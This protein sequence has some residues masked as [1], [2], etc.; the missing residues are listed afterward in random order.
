MMKVKYT[1]V[2]SDDVIK[3]VFQD[4]AIVVEHIS[5]ELVFGKTLDEPTQLEETGRYEDTFDF[6][7]MPNGKLELFD[8]NTGEWLIETELPESPIISAERVDGVLWVELVNFFGG[9]AIDGARELDWFD[10]K[11]VELDG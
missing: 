4:D 6:R 3:Y 7:D 11:E 2:R 1:Y 9:D 10:T 5:N 8:A